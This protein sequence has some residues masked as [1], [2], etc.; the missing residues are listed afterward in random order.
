MSCP[1]RLSVLILLLL[2]LLGV[3]V[4]LRQG[5]SMQSGLSW[6]L[7]CGLAGLKLRDTPVSASK[8][9]RLKVCVT[10]PGCLFSFLKVLKIHKTKAVT[11]SKAALYSCFM[12]GHQVWHMIPVTIICCAV[13]WGCRL[14]IVLI[15]LS[16]PQ[17]QMFSSGKISPLLNYYWFP[18]LPG[19]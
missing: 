13:V 1:P 10:T 11:L 14:L 18:C 3:L 7:L 16:F 8:V 6:N 2:L 17:P 15:L 4:F 19:E 9:L 12:Q 5:L